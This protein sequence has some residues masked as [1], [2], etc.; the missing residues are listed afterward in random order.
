MN[1][2]TRPPKMIV[3]YG[4]FSNAGRSCWLAVRNPKGA[5]DFHHELLE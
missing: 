2:R 1:Y 5:R 4:T 3:T